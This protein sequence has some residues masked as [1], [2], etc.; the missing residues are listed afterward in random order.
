LS[1]TTLTCNAATFP[2]T[3][4]QIFLTG[5]INKTG[6]LVTT[7]SI[8]SAT[9]DPNLN[10]TSASD[11]VTGVLAAANG[12]GLANTGQ[13]TALIVGSAIAL[14]AAALWVRERRRAH[15]RV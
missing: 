4:Y 14:I 15:Q 9:P 3:S 7:A 11:T 2:V 12:G 1:G 5:V 13:K 10:D 6:N 8:T